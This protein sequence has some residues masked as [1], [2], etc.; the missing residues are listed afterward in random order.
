MTGIVDLVKKVQ[1]WKSRLIEIESEVTHLK[2]R[3]AFADEILQED[4]IEPQLVALPAQHL[5]AAKSG[6]AK[7]LA[8]NVR[9]IFKSYPGTEFGNEDVFQE[10]D[11]RG[12]KFEKPSV[13]AT[14]SKMAKKG[15]VISRKEGKITKYSLI[16]KES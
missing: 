16:K 2:G 8:E 13:Y 5:G 9:E 4:G 10:L 14:L 11:T 7:S 3:I 1:Q 6:V 12:I 15:E